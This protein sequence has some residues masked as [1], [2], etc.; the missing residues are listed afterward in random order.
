MKKLK[1]ICL[2]LPTGRTFTFKDVTIRC[3]NETVLEFDYVAMSDG[4]SKHITI[5]KT[6]IVG[7]SVKRS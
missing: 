1:S 3:N 5:Q 6:Q 7:Y 4:M 2:F